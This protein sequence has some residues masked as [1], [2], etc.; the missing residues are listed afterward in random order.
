[1]D[2][3]GISSKPSPSKLFG[4][5]LNHGIKPINYVGIMVMMFTAFFVISIIIAF[6]VSIL[7]DPKYY[8][9]DKSNIGKQVGNV[10]STVEALV[11]TQDFLIG[12]IIDAFGRK[13]PI[14]VAWLATAIALFLMP[15][16]NTLWPGYFLCRLFMSLGCVLCMNMP[17]LPDYVAP[18]SM[19]LAQSVIQ[20][21][22]GLGSMAGS[23]G[24]F[25]LH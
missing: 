21:C 19:G 4:I 16:F 5:V 14:L 23:S 10:A 8:D 17:L 22:C 3:S 7:E 24:M 1:M 6:S 20:I 12:P 2:D 13:I 25:A 11:I 15:M 9:L 18:E